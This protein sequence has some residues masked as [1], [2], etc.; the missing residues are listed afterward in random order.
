M[1]IPTPGTTNDTIQ[2]HFIQSDLQ[3]L[4]L[5]TDC[6]PENLEILDLEI[7]DLRKRRSF[8]GYCNR[9]HVTTGTK[10]SRYEF[11]QLSY[12]EQDSSS[13]RIGREISSTMGTGGMGIFGA[14]LAAKIIIAKGLFATV[15]AKET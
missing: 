15:Q 7:D 9:A 12:A 8:V 6:I 1:L 2:W 4:Y 14:G 11:F 13:L 3:D 10:D 5:P